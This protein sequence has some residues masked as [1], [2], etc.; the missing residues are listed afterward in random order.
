M[1]LAAVTLVGLAATVVFA[2]YWSSHPVDVPLRFVGR[3][4]CVDCHQAEAEAFKG[5]HHDLAMDRATDDTVLGDFDNATLTHHGITSRMFRDRDR[6]MIHTEGPSGEMADFEIQYVFGVDPLQQYMVAFDDDDQRDADELPRLQVL[7]ISWDTRKKEWFYLPPPDVDEKLEP[8]DPLHWTGIAQRWQTMCADCHSTNLHRGF[9]VDDQRYHTTFTDIDV[10]CESCHGPGS[11]H[12]E[13]A[14]SK[15]LFWDRHHGYGLPRLKGDDPEPQLQSCAPCHSRRGLL[16]ESFTAGSHYHNHFDLERFTPAT[17]HADGQI[18]DEVY[19]YGSFIQSKMYHKGI[20]CTDCHDPHTARLIHRGNEVC[21]SC[22]QHAGGKYDTPSHHHHAV[23]TAGAQCINCHMPHTTYMEVDDRHDHSLRVPR[24]DLSVQ[25]G[26]PNACSQCHLKDIK[27]DLP[28]EKLADLTQYR[29]WIQAAEAGDESIRQALNK[30]DRWCDQACDQW[31]GEDRKQPPHFAEAVVAFRQGETGAASRLLKFATDPQTPA[32]VRASLLDEASM[33]GRAGGMTVYQAKKL[34][35][36]PELDLTG[37]DE[38]APMVLA[39]AA[40]A[41]LVESPDDIR[42]ALAPLLDHNVKLVRTTAA[43]VILRGNAYPTLRK[44]ERESFDRVLDEIREGIDAV[45]DR[46]GAHM[47]WA[48]FAEARGEFQ[49]A[50]QA[51]ETAIRVE[52]NQTGPR[53]NLA[54]LLERLASAYPPNEA[55]ELC[56]RSR[57]LRRQELPLLARDAGLAP[58]LAPIQYRYGLA[59]YLDGQKQASLKQLEKVVRIAPGVPDYRQAYE[60]LR[61]Q[62]E[63]EAAK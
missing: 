61:A 60:A 41:L 12:I 33:S 58:D 21:T 55:A 29:D 3:S 14:R 38:Q 6:F 24:P 25:L 10:S 39:A 16:D 2:D 54:E 4:A 8:N 51:Y 22:H 27:K 5:S 35:G 17:Y 46:A 59:L 40:R 23:G 9:D 63:N 50:I 1:P 11:L 7:R 45:A 13:L 15:S 20:R 31:Y 30:L 32:L 48:T 52:P 62:L 37:S 19:V 28:A 56:E 18:K 53:S 44:Q 57:Q 34:L 36:A 47:E 42:L 49:D 43:R 26:T